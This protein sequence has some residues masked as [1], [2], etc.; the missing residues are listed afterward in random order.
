[1]LVIARE[2]EKSPVEAAAMKN[3]TKPDPF[4]DLE[5]MLI[6]MSSR[7]VDHPEELVVRPAPGDNFIAFEVR[8]PGSDLGTL[9]GRRGVLAE[10]MRKLLSA[11]ATVHGVRVHVQFLAL[12]GSGHAGR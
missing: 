9:L 4:K 8:C 10:A 12:D 2:Q 6:A 5:E 1:M 7:L 11:A 3:Q